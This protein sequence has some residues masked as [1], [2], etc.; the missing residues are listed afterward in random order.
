VVKT[1]R[2]TRNGRLLLAGGGEAATSGRVVVWD[3]AQAARIAELGEEYD[4]VLAADA[5][6]RAF[7]REAVSARQAAAR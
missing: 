3:V 7:A 1:V 2:F 4:E 5:E 6:A